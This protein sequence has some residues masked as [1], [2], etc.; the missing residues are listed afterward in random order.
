MGSTWR[1]L[2]PRIDDCDHSFILLCRN[3]V[4]CSRKHVI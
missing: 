3:Y 2:E 4:L 1:K